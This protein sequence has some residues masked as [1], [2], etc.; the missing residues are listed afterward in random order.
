MTKLNT[1]YGKTYNMFERRK[2]SNK[3]NLGI[4]NCGDFQ[5]VGYWLVTEKIDGTNVRVILTFADGVYVADVRGRSDNANL[6]K[7]FV[8]EAFGVENAYDLTENLYEALCQLTWAGETSQ[9]E[10]DAKLIEDPITMVV[11]G[12]GYGPGIQ[13]GGKYATKKSFRAFDVV[14]WKNGKA[15]WR[16]WEDVTQVAEFLGVNTVPVFSSQATTRDIV[17]NVGGE[18]NDFLSIVAELENPDFEEDVDRFGAEGIIARTD[19]YLYDYRGKRVMFKLKA[20]DMP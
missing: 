13:K 12:E 15:L 2:D 17:E 11:Y 18:V 6:P 14:T 16:T 1:E 20:K 10:L 3:V 5:Q 7:G 9:E 4:W 8:Q 19:P